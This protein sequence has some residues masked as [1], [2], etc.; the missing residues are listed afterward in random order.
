MKGGVKLKN[1]KFIRSHRERLVHAKEIIINEPRYRNERIS[2]IDR[3]AFVEFLLLED[4]CKLYEH[5]LEKEK[6]YIP[7]GAADKK[8]KE[9][10]IEK[11]I[12]IIKVFEAAIGAAR[13]AI[14]SGDYKK[15]WQAIHER[16]LM[17][18]S[19]SIKYLPELRELAVTMLKDLINDAVSGTSEI[20]K[21]DEGLE[22]LYIHE[23][24][25]R[26]VKGVPENK[27]SID[28]IIKAAE[29]IIPDKK[30]TN[31]LNSNI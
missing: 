28:E 17:T 29:N 18:A 30:R 6:A 9:A 19:N 3:E 22:Y 27:E 7:N 1:E 10:N 8:G 5:R 23:S 12:A 2:I 15:V 16:P 11:F 26:F 25:L 14:N 21:L 20:I 24:N 13:S 31:R 4:I